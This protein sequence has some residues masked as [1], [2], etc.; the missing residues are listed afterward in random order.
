MSRVDDVALI[1]I[2]RIPLQAQSSLFFTL[3]LLLLTSNMADDE[4]A[5]LMKRL[6]EDK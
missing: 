3:L 1:V 5:V 2:S 6:N 4:H